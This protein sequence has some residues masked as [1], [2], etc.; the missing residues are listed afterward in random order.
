MDGLLA[1]GLVL[2]SLA[3]AIGGLLAVA[4]LHGTGKRANHSV[5]LD[6]AQGTVF[7]FDGD[8]LID[9]TAGAR[10]L[11]SASRARGGNWQRMIAYLTP[12]FPDIDQQL[13]RLS[14]E[15]SIA[16]DSRSETGK[17]LLLNAELNCGVTRITLS[18]PSVGGKALVTD[19]L[20]FRAMNEE[21]GQLREVIAHAP[22]LIWRE[23]LAGEVVWANGAY[24]MRAISLMPVGK[25]LGWPLPRIFERTATQK[26]VQGQRAAITPPGEATLWYD[27]VG[28]AV[29]EEKLVF[30]LP[31]DAAVQSET[32]LRD[33]MQTLTKTFAQLPI[34]LAI[35]DRQRQ[36]QLFNPALLDLTGLPA[37]MLSLR[38]TLLTVLDALRDRNMI[39]EPKDYRNWR[40]QLVEMEKAAASGLYQER[41]NLPDGQ[42]FQVTGR[43]HPNGALALM[44]EDITHEVSR[45]RRYR[46]DLELGQAVI[47][48][49]EE[50]VAVFSASGQ[51]VMS[52]M[53][54]AT[55]WPQAPGA[56]LGEGTLR[57][58]ALHWRAQTAPGVLWSEVEEFIS[59]V[60]DRVAWR[61]E[62]RL[63][64]GRG[65]HCRFAPLSGGATL[66]AF[67]VSDSNE[68][69]QPHLAQIAAR[70][71][72]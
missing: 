45:S 1:L 56:N 28:F 37:D 33:F 11:L 6:S 30:A 61:A 42:T 54:Y 67:R 13:R 19:P 70:K 29:K 4:A 14:L 46:S 40:R 24:L 21:L 3:A 59:T 38:P 66:A 50:A 16:L 63:L 52:N 26:T 36:L 48:E 8:T 9:S 17:P 43:P 62:T 44:I 51:L 23:S 5:F 72:A 53:G 58:V 22:T 12:Y 15:G 34:G 35:F 32:A 64:D 47:D 18:D 7:L 31:A 41:W 69:A 57:E 71:S 20:A 65:L 49:M 68:A 55:L 2:I 10:Q 27:L 25:E 39:P 60:G